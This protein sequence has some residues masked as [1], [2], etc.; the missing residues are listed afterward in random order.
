MP[1][2]V[3]ESQ[4]IRFAVR[5]GLPAAALMPACAD[6]QRLHSGTT[7]SRI[8]YAKLHVGRRTAVIILVGLCPSSRMSGRRGASAEGKVGIIILLRFDFFIAVHREKGSHDGIKTVE[9][10][11]CGAV[12]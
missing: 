9:L 10:R 5:P 4:A 6:L 7:G 2:V 12:A 11:R 3:P 1:Y 8:V